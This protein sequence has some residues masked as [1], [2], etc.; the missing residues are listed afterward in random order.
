MSVLDCEEQPSC[1]F[2]LFSNRYYAA[3]RPVASNLAASIAT[4]LLRICCNSAI[5]IPARC[6]IQP[7][8]VPRTC[9]RSFQLPG[10]SVLRS[11][12]VHAAS[13]DCFS[14][15][16]ALYLDSESLSRG[17]QERAATGRSDVEIDELFLAH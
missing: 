8:G 16:T 11:Q 17:I 15:H 2:I 3:G 4:R 1:Y 9:V 12:G 5:D 7:L 14:P 6:Y 10:W 13:C